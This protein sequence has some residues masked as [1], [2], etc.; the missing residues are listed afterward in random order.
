MNRSVNHLFAGVRIVVLCV[1]S[2]SLA[3]P[4]PVQAYAVLSHEAIID[5][6]WETHIKPLLLKKFPQA[7]EEDLSR[8]QAYAYGGAII[9]DM[10]YY[11]YGSH[12]FSNLTHYVRSGDFILALLRNAK[13]I[14][15][16]AFAIGALAHYAADN[17]GHRIGTNRAVPILYPSLRKKYGDSVS[18]EDNALA[19]VKTEFGFDVLEIAHERYAPDSYHDFIGFEVSRPVLD[20]AF[21]ETY[22]LEL[23]E[24]LLNEEKALSS[25]RHDV[26]KLIPKATH[27]AWSLKKDE[28]KSD[29]PD[30]TKR[31]FL[32]N[33]SRSNYEREWGKDY[34][35]PSPGERF[36]AFLYKLI[37][38]FGPLKILQ[39]RTPTPQT[40]RMFEASFNATLD[41][42]RELLVDVREG[43]L[44]LPNNN[45]DV[46]ENTGPGKYRLSDEAHAELLDKLAEGKFAN[47]APELKAELLHFFA[48]PDAPYATKKKPEAWSKVQVQLQQLKDTTLTSAPANSRQ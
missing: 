26:S 25:Y 1:L 43:R 38:K 14:P 48:D 15:E 10:G 4:S 23:K 13:D 5:A 17:N 32:Y 42:Y 16:Y 39:F 35:K 27:I 41:R 33:L 20:Q 21:R 47:T 34:R 40:E 31:K 22:G 8:A 36:L 19:H 46:G 37:P 28:I 18:Y 24:V 11:P 7:T 45:F 12:F 9:Q 44:D 2:I 3:L 29:I 30:A 6:S